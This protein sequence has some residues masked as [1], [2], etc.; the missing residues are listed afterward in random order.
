MLFPGKYPQLEDGDEA[1]LTAPYPP[2]LPLRAPARMAAQ[3]AGG[4]A[5]GPWVP[6]IGA[7]EISFLIETQWLAEA[8]GAGPQP[9]DSEHFRPAPRTCQS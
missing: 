3:V 2:R 9:I 7:D 5:R 8:E 6:D 1:C 4:A